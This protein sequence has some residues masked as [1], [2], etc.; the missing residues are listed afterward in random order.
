MMYILSRDN[1]QAHFFEFLLY[2]A[3]RNAF[4]THLHFLILTR[5]IFFEYFLNFSTFESLICN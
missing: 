4:I 2:G 3:D 5:E 1:V